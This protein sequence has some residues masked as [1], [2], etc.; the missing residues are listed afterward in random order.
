MHLAATL[1][2]WLYVVYLEFRINR[3]KRIQEI[4]TESFGHQI[5]A[6]N[7][8]RNLLEKIVDASDIRTD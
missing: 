1:C 5:K 7:A 4:H 6:N 3:M 2:L 8:V